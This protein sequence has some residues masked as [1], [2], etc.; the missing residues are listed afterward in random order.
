MATYSVNFAAHAKKPAADAEKLA[1]SGGFGA[2]NSE[3]PYETTYGAGN[4]T[5]GGG[6]GGRFGAFWT[7]FSGPGGSCGHYELYFMR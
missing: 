4:K 3:N 5:V 7:L 1:V 2:E 6:L